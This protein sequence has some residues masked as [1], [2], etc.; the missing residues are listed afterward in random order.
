MV[1]QLSRAFAS[2]DINTLNHTL[3]QLMVQ[4]VVQPIVLSTFGQMAIGQMVIRYY[5][6]YFRK[7]SHNFKMQVATFADALRNNRSGTNTKPV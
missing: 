2:N 5:N 1:K 3:V 7:K 6:E 4:P